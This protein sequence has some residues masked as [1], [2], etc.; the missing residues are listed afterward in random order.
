[1]TFDSEFTDIGYDKYGV[2]PYS[3]DLLLATTENNQFGFFDKNGNLIIDLEKYTDKFNQAV[4]SGYFSNGT[5]KINYPNSAGV[6]FEI[7][8][9]KQG[10][11]I[12]EVS[13]ME[14]KD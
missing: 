14:T 8:M 9:D 4:T 12:S 7:T 13:E 6:F 3:E 5:F 2:Y 11:I 1:M 10:N